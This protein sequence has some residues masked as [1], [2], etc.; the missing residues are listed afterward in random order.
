MMIN[1]GPNVQLTSHDQN[2]SLSNLTFS[3]SLTWIKVIL[4]WISSVVFWLR[5]YWTALITIYCK[6]NTK[7]YS[8]TPVAPADKGQNH[9]PQYTYP[10]QHDQFRIKAKWIHTLTSRC[11]TANI[12]ALCTRWGAVHLFGIYTKW[13]IHLYFQPEM[14][15]W[16]QK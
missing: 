2:V 3:G 1:K 15:R 11:Y 4:D 6:R 13:H 14:K 10:Q 9:W 12:P 8:P 7:W 5:C 16:V